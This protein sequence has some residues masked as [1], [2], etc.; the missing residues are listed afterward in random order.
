M[1]KLSD[2]RFNRFIL[3]DAKTIPPFLDTKKV[4]HYNAFQSYQYVNSSLLYLCIR[5]FVDDFVI[6]EAAADIEVIFDVIEKKSNLD[7]KI[8]FFG[9]MLQMFGDYIALAEELEEY[10]MARNISLLI[11]EINRPK[12]KKGK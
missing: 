9:Y 11:V 10:E 8:L 7:L 3:D 1:S 5:A 2:D 4:E 12:N 6:K